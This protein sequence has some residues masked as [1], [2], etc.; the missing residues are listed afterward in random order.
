MFL[1]QMSIFIKIRVHRA[2][3]NGHEQM[4]RVGQTF[5]SSLRHEYQYLILRQNLKRIYSQ[6]NTWIKWN[7]ERTFISLNQDIKL[8]RVMTCIL[9]L[10]TEEQEQLK[11]YISSA[12]MNLGK[13]HV[14]KKGPRETWR[15]RIIFLVNV[16]LLS[17]E[18]Q[19]MRQN[20]HS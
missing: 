17:W 8:I 13:K 10:H 5:Y 20:S 16:H 1:I 2:R 12:L 7:L 3:R 4:E 14:L 11:L 15:I 18:L 9:S 6:S 19:K